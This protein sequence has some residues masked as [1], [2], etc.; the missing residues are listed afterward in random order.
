MDKPKSIHDLDTPQLLLDL[1]GIDANLARMFAAAKRYGVKV[2]VHF[3]SL[4]CT[5][6]ARYI[7]ER[8]ADG[9]L[10][11]KLHEAES[12]VRAELTDVMIANQV[13]GENKLRRLAELAG[14]GAIRVCVD[15][16]GQVHALAAAA[17]QEGTTIGVLI[18]VDIGMR[19]CGV[20][21]G[22]AAI[23]LARAIVLVDTLHPIHEGRA[24]RWSR[25]TR[26]VETLEYG[27]TREGASAEAW[28]RSPL[29]YMVE[30]N[31]SVLRRRLTDPAPSDGM[32]DC[33]SFAELR[34]EGMTD[35]VALV[36]RFAAT[37]VVGEM[38]AIY[39]F[40]TSDVADGFSDNYVL[41]LQRLITPLAA[42]LKSVSL[43][44]IATTLV[45]TYLGRD[46]TGS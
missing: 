26:E 45:E 22:E 21:P 19:R 4:K 12:L 18:E 27:R 43:A 13:V 30:T 3:K 37:S 29:Y 44:R 34:S 35:Y 32:P 39:S 11:A 1:D 10:C 33:A 20:A 24:F 16:V 7:A 2:R 40:W 9:F 46:D 23:P 8:G 5:G 31:Q 42:A 38:D 36:T 14:R 28:R 6:L 41:M 17:Q 15:D 25:G